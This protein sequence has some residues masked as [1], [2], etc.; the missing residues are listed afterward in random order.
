MTISSSSSPSPID[1]F[2]TRTSVSTGTPW[3]R[4][5]GYSRAVRVGP[6]VFV[7]GTIAADA[8]GNLIGEGDP[9][10]QATAIL[11]KTE[12]ALGEL[13]AVMADVVSTRLYVTNIDDSEAIGRAHRDRFGEIRPCATMVEVSR[14]ALPGAVVEIE[15]MAI[16]AR[17]IV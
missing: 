13:G 15:V 4:A 1:E 3:E 8:A 5:V 11:D 9:F 6:L 16:S 17:A 12:A 2:W 14:L 7:T 10:S